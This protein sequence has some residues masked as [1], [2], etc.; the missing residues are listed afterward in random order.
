MR[1]PFATSDARPLVARSQLELVFESSVCRTDGVANPIATIAS[2]VTSARKSA[3]QRQTSALATSV[4]T[5]SAAKLD[6]ENETSRPAQITH[7]VTTATATSSAARSYRTTT[8][9][10]RIATTRKRPYTDGS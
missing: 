10:A 8:T 5:I 6:C 7:P 4:P 1:T 9:A 2:A 3:R